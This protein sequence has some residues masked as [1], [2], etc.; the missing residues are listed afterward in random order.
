VVIDIPKDIQAQE[1]SDTHH[2]DPLA[3]EPNLP[4]FF[5]SPKPERGLIHTAGEMIN[6]S[7]RPIIISG[8]GVIM[9]DAGQKLRQFAEKARIPVAYTLHGLSA[10]PA[11][12]FYN[13]RYAGTPMKNPDFGAIAGAYGIP[14]LQVTAPGDIEEA[15]NTAAAHKGAYL[16]EFLCDPSEIVLPM[17]PAGGGIKDMIVKRENNHGN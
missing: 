9:A 5:Y 12:H 6:Q 1:A 3:Y 14:H 2:F 15:L 10:M 17:V 8:H 4:G 11:D 13:G 7:E 16:V